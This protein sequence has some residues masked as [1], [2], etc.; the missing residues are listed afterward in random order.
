[1]LVNFTVKNYRSFKDE[2]TFSMEASSIEEHEESVIKAGNQRLLPLTIIYGANSSGKSNLIFAIYTMQ[3]MVKESV[4]LNESDPLLYDP[5]ALDERFLAR[6]PRYL[7]CNSFREKT[8]IV[9][10]LSTPKK[11][12]FRNGCTKTGLAKRK[13]SFSSVQKT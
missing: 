9:T 6:L 4:R 10:D 11:K 2:R 3:R 13:W 7:R 5:F 8:A 12:L 1:M